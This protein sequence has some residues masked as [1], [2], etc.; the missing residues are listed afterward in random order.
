MARS[1]DFDPKK[2]HLSQLAYPDWVI[3]VGLTFRQATSKETIVMFQLLRPDMMTLFYTSVTSLS[4]KIV[5]NYHMHQDEIRAL[6]KNIHSRT[7][8]SCDLWSS[9]NQLTSRFRLTS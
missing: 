4:K 9:P 6:F 2:Q 5:A 8:L 1:K 7:H 3:V